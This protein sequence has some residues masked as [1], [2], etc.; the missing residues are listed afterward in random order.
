MHGLKYSN[1]DFFVWVDK[2][3]TGKTN[4][5]L[6]IKYKFDENHLPAVIITNQDSTILKRV[7]TVD[8]EVYV[9]KKHL[10]LSYI[11]TVKIFDLEGHSKDNFVLDVIKNCNKAIV[12]LVAEMSEIQACIYSILE[13][14]EHNPNCRIAVLANR[15]K[16]DEQYNLITEHINKIGEYPIFRFPD[17]R[18]MPNMFVKRQSITQMMQS[19]AL[20]CRAFANINNEYLKI[21][22]YLNG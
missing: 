6:G 20:M 2:G 11:N 4:F 19:S 1:K 18:A 5:S 8:K 21:F 14:K 7:L 22:S 9:L 16:S 10:D 12:P 15:I 3:G 17:S 13:I